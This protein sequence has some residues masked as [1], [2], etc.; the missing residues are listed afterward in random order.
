MALT[1]LIVSLACFYQGSGLV[2]CH[3]VF[4]GFS[5]SGVQ[6]VNRSMVTGSRYHKPR[7]SMASFLLQEEPQPL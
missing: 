7:S 2:L 5:L 6:A 3:W 4:A 1:I